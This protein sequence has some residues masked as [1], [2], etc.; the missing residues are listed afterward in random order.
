VGTLPSAVAVIFPPWEDT[1]HAKFCT[2]VAISYQLADKT[3]E[4]Q[5]RG[6]KNLDNEEEWKLPRQT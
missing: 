4:Q 1:E 2:P 5:N 6:A 3:F